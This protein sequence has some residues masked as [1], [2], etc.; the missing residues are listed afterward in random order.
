MH[1]AMILTTLINGNLHHIFLNQQNALHT[2]A[3]RAGAILYVPRCAKVIVQVVENQ[4]CIEEVTIR[5]SS[6]NSS[7]GIR[8]G[9]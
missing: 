7:E 9:P 8:Y 1:R 3:E 6:D 4:I 2:L 5:V